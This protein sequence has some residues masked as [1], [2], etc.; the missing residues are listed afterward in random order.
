M[1]GIEAT[2]NTLDGYR[3]VIKMKQMSAAVSNH[4]S[5]LYSVDK[6][7]EHVQVKNV[8]VGGCGWVMGG[9]VCVG[10]FS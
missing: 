6:L 4:T 10:V 5:L 1:K 7:Y 8:G 2:A 9:W 3:R